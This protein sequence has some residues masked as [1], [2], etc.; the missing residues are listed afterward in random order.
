MSTAWGKIH[1]DL[2]K[3]RKFRS[4]P[5][6]ARAA[7]TMA[8]SYSIAQGT[9]GLIEDYMLAALEITAEDVSNLLSNGL[10]DEVEGGYV[11]HDWDEHQTS[12]EHAEKVS[13]VRS[14]AGRKGGLKRQEKPVTSENKQNGSNL[15]SKTEANAKQAGSK[16]QA[17][18]EIE[19]EIEKEKELTPLPPR[20]K[21][22]GVY[23]DA[24]EAWWA[25]YP[26]KADKRAALGAWRRARKRADDDVL[27]AGAERYRDDPNRE[28]RFTKNAAT[29][30]NSDAWENEP[31]P[32]RMDTGPSSASRALHAVSLYQ[33]MEQERA[34][35]APFDRCGV[36]E[37]HQAP[38]GGTRRPLAAHSGPGPALVDT[39][40]NLDAHRPAY[41]FRRTA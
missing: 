22:A 37:S 6:E 31:L 3:H 28:D 4:L 24:F 39:R 40:G 11:F 16:T 12:R 18:I 14:E 30:L 38:P 32:S 33:E 17:E 23:P 1:G 2:W 15:L 26:K 25:V 34:S 5:K 20:S 36:L 7:W 21:R 35:T 8:L 27:I 41:G 19:I 10:W 13:R 9:F 29:W